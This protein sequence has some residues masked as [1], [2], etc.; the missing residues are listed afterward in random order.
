MIQ[1][2][3]RQGDAAQA[4][5]KWRHTVAS[6]EAQD[7]LHWVMRIASHRRIRMVIDITS[8]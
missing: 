1:N 2:L 5:A 7:V 4:L 8:I 6:S 3:G